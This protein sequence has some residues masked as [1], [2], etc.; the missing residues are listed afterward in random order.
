MTEAPDAKRPIELV[1]RRLACQNSKLRAH[2]DWLR[3]NDSVEV[4]DYMVVSSISMPADDI[5]GP[6]LHPTGVTILP[7]QPGR[8]GLLRMFRH[9]MGDWAWEAPRGFIDEGEDAQTAALRELTE[10]TGLEALADDLMDLGAVVPEGGVIRA[11]NRLF[12][13]L[14]CLLSNVSEGEMGVDKLVWFEANEAVRMAATSQIED[15]TTT[16]ALL[17]YGLRIKDRGE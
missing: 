10:E 11:R 13:A 3:W 4:P 2:F 15:A 14:N 12:A 1:S 9:P 7:V 6:L 16:I 17:R 8:I 5:A